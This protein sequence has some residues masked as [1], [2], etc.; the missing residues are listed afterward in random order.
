MLL[1]RMERKKAVELV[2]AKEKLTAFRDPR[3]REMPFDQDELEAALRESDVI[4]ELQ[5]LD[6]IKWDQLTHAYGSARDVPLHLKRLASV[7]QDI[8]RRAFHNLV[9]TIFHQETLYTATAPAIPFLLQLASMP[10]IPDRIELLELIYT[11]VR[12]CHFES[13]KTGENPDDPA[14]VI[15]DNLF[16]HRESLFKLRSDDNTAISE[17][18][19]DII[20]TLI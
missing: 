11:I 8:R 10:E 18:A 12:T 6:D 13:L 16:R 20:D 17:I 3:W 5:G 19:G 4:I 1:G 7:D 15:Y 2:T 14:Y 9:M